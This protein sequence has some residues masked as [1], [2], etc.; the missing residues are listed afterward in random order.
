MVNVCILV[1]G[2]IRNIRFG[3]V[4]L[5]TNFAGAIDQ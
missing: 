4:M 1:Q 3:T 2:I 5:L